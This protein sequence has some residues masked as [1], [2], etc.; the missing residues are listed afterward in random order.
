MIIST[1]FKFLSSVSSF[2]TWFTYNWATASLKF[3]FLFF[4]SLRTLLIGEM[5]LFGRFSTFCTLIIDLLLDLLENT[6][7]GRMR[8]SGLL[9]LRLLC[10]SI[11]QILGSLRGNCVG[12]DTINSYGVMSFFLLAC[13][14]SKDVDITSSV[15]HFYQ[16]SHLDCLNHW[17]P[18]QK[19]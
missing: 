3:K 4:G 15:K 6:C 5:L 18:A 12:G 2:L 7:F 8:K 1:L 10:S 11:V 13:L 16:S 17:F 9:T 14:Q 19:T